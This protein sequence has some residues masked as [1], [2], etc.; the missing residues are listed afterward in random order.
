MSGRG[1]PAGAALL[2]E[3]FT[4]PVLLTSTTADAEGSFQIVVTVPPGARQGAAVIR[5]STQGGSHRAESS[6]RV[7]DPSALPGLL[8]GVTRSI[9]DILGLG[10]SG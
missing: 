6:I 7:T 2:V 10:L 1:Y 4:D 5:V 9:L 3:L 8:D